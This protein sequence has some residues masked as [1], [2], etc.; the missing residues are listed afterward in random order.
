SADDAVNNLSKAQLRRATRIRKNFALLSSFLLFIAV[1]FLILVEIGGTYNRPILR[2]IYFLRLDLSHIVPRSIPNAILI[3]SIAQTLGLHDFYSVALWGFCEG[4]N[5]QG[6]TFC[7]R[8]Q[9]LYWFNPVEILVNEL[10]AGATIAL[11]VDLLD[12]LNIL[13]TASEWMFA[14]F[15]TGACLSTVM[16]FI[17]P[18]SVYSRWTT[19]PV[20][21]LTF[22][23]AL[24]T[25]VAT[26]L[27]TVMFVIVRNVVTKVEELSIGANLGTKM[28]V[29]MWIASGFTICAWLIQTGLCCCCASR[30]DVRKGKKKGTVK[31][32]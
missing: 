21:I 14:L 27:A 18:I 13:K 17:T 6:V 31:A 3:N 24:T 8:P 9:S 20:A 12:V 11:P 4:Y 10:L 5:G 15:L 7:S 23:A 19:L 25:T 16:I 29:F 26:V 22:V 28:F 30:R 1:L 32:Y 2:D